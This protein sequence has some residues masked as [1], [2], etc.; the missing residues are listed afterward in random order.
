MINTLNCTGHGSASPVPSDRTPAEPS[1]TYYDTVGSAVQFSI[2]L[3]VH[4][5][6]LHFWS[7]PV[8]MVQDSVQNLTE[9]EPENTHCS[10]L[11]HLGSCFIVEGNEVGQAWFSFKECSLPTPDC[12]LVIC[13]DR[14][15]LQ[16]ET[17]HQLS[18]DWGEA[19]FFK[20]QSGLCFL[21]VLRDLFWSPQP[22]K[23]NSKQPS[24]DVHQLSLS[25]LV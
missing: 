24:Q 11:I 3:T 16:N 12:F 7:F 20:D 10:V 9:V 1:A 8:N 17:L 13:V 4:W 18:E 14:E 5:S 2:L 15:S 23:D 21:P 19:D 22:F 6:S 25:I